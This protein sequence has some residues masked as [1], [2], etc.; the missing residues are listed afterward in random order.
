M[1]G[2]FSLISIKKIKYLNKQWCEIWLYKII[3]HVNGVSDDWFCKRDNLNLIKIWFDLD[4]LL[5]LKLS[6]NLFILIHSSVHPI[7]YYWVL[8]DVINRTGSNL[9]LF[10]TYI[11]SFRIY[12]NNIIS[13]WISSTNK[14][15]AF[16]HRPPRG[17][18]DTTTE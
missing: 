16:L 13:N 4:K 14:S 17:I 15:G 12:T 8:K 2:N 11:T 5:F 3:L 9:H 10:Q 7:Y 1:P 18:N 6:Y